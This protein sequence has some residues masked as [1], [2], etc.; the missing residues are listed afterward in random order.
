M[1][2]QLLVG[3]I[4][5]CLVISSSNAQTHGWSEEGYTAVFQACLIKAGTD[6]A[7]ELAC[8]GAETHR[9]D[10]MLNAAYQK[11]SARLSPYQRSL[12][13]KSER[14]WIVFRDSE[15]SFQ[16]A[17]LIGGPLGIEA[18]AQTQFKSECLLRQTHQRVRVLL[19]DYK[20]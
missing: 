20:P 5:A 7:A 19:S 3:I 1:L 18:T 15:C 16:G 6:V 17:Q 10:A 8:Q 2:R 11:L 13:V 4:T 12:L 14:A 9:Q